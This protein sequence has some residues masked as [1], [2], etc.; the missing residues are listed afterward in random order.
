M[1]TIKQGH[2]IHETKDVLNSTRQ[3][4]EYTCQHNTKTETGK[5]TYNIHLHHKNTMVS[6]IT[7]LELSAATQK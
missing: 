5:Q 3:A 7:A 6:E 4:K 2:P 1:E